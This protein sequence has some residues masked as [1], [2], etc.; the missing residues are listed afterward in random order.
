MIFSKGGPLSLWFIHLPIIMGVWI[1]YLLAT[2]Q[3][4]EKNICMAISC[5]VAISLF[6]SCIP[7]IVEFISRNFRKII[8]VS[9]ITATVAYI[10]INGLSIAAAI[11][12]GSVIIA[13]TIWI[14]R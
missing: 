1:F 9:C 8:V 3:N 2:Y 4:T 7:Y 12:I 5:S 14:K 10:T 13:A 6:I 11:I